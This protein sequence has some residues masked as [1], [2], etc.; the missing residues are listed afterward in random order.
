MENKMFD[1]E[2]NKISIRMGEL[3][4]RL[5]ELT[6]ERQKVR[7]EQTKLIESWERITRNGYKPVST[8]CLKEPRE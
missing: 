2:L 1:E 6:E 5:K 7:D 4:N 3:N 8:N